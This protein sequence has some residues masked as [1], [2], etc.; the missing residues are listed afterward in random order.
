MIDARGEIIGRDDELARALDLLETA[1]PLTLLGAPGIGK[2][3]LAHELAAR[4]P[5]A[6][7]ASLANATD[8]ASVEASLAEAFRA[9]PAARPTSGSIAASLASRAPTLLVLDD[10]DAV[11]DVLRDVLSQL[12]SVFPLVVTAR[13]RLGTPDEVVL[14]LEPLSLRASDDAPSDAARL[15]ISAHERQRR[16][17]R[18]ATPRPVSLEDAEA[19]ARSAEGVPLALELAAGALGALGAR[20]AVDG[21]P[22]LLRKS[23]RGDD[24]SARAL[25]R[26]W[27]ALGVLEQQALVAVAAIGAP[28]DS[29]L[30]SVALAVE[31]TTAAERLAELRA[32]SLV[33]PSLR[34]DDALEV[35]PLVRELAL[36]S[37]APGEADAA[38]LRLLSSF[39]SSSPERGAFP[40]EPAVLAVAAAL[41]HREPTLV[42]EALT[43]IELDARSLPVQARVLA[44]ASLP[45]ATRAHLLKNRAWALFTSGHSRRALEAGTEAIETARRAAR[46]DLLGSAAIGAVSYAVDSGQLERAHELLAIARAA[47]FDERTDLAVTTST[48]FLLDQEG[49]ADEAM[50]LLT[51][52]ATPRLGAEPSP[53]HR[54]L[55]STIGAMRAYA[56]AAQGDVG[57]G[58]HLL[59]VASAASAVDGRPLP[60]FRLVEAIFLHALGDPSAELLMREMIEELLVGEPRWAA[61]GLAHLAA[62]EAT[63]G[64]LERSTRTLGRALS[65][66]AD[67][68]T[69]AIGV[70][71]T[72]AEAVVSAAGDPRESPSFRAP[73]PAPWARVLEAIFPRVLAHRARPSAPP[74]PRGALVVDRA[75][76]YFVTSAG[77]TV[78]LG[79]RHSLRRLLAAVA[80]AR[81][82]PSSWVSIEDAIEAAWPGDRSSTASLKNRLR[83]A[84]TTLRKM[85]LGEALEG[86]RRGYRLDPAIAID[87]A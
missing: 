14:E 68:D 40:R 19:L 3:R 48:A 67:M 15:V 84:I 58:L 33:T 80:R 73:F 31:A 28:F 41:A 82:T 49:H 66:A 63:S 38:R 44:E 26:G 60:R 47:A 59:R 75:G 11:R 34:F 56:A 37:A 70:S 8:L 51:P 12:P 36:A 45:D 54:F 76:A 24:A 57:T 87:L 81:E 65:L 23:V 25:R 17:R 30:A 20:S 16:H 85:G 27:D 1:R 86:A 35:T 62:L 71:L 21:L 69:R 5:D 83:V 29:R 43:K 55:P 53:L 2:T 10:V 9:A 39:A 50:A 7:V 46:D 79:R 74:P 42:G 72:W 18:G 64:R 78:H 77:E 6:V 61:G 22:A 13:S 4:H 52:L 32:S